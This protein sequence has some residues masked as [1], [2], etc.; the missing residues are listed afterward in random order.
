MKAQLGAKPGMRRAYTPN[1]ALVF[2]NGEAFLRPEKENV[3]RF[4]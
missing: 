2:E 4:L 1:F 3:F